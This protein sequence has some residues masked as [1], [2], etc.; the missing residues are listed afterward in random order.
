MS[1]T[2]S[3]LPKTF[4]Q[5]PSF[6]AKKCFT[7]QPQALKDI[8][9]SKENF[10]ITLFWADSPTFEN[11]TTIKTYSIPKDYSLKS[12]FLMEVLGIDSKIEPGEYF[13][14]FDDYS[15][16]TN[17][18]KLLIETSYFGFGV[19][20]EESDKNNTKLSLDPVKF[21]LLFIGLMPQNVSMKFRISFDRLIDYCQ[22]IVE[23]N[24]QLKSLPEFQ[25]VL[26]ECLTA[27]ANFFIK[28]DNLKT[29]KESCD[30]MLEV[31]ANVSTK[32]LLEL[33]KI[34][35]EIRNFGEAE[36]MCKEILKSDTQ[37]N[38]AK[39]VL[40]RLIIEKKR[41]ELHHKKVYEEI[42]GKSQKRDAPLLGRATR[43][44]LLRRN[45]IK[46]LSAIFVLFLA[47]LSIFFYK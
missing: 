20:A 15:V 31:F 34:H 27:K 43:Q 18:L 35:I 32:V 38:E 23:P 17:S 5:M 28:E 22:M 16:L 33:I 9:K 19:S 8:E 40:S 13:V 47:I 1:S 7:H 42:C 36:S 29:V 37:N 21:E 30:K 44:Q 4:Q 25:S 26:I 12:T 3:T 41:C 46:I 6:N 2:D 14:N 24:E 39:T 45:R 11:K 10:M